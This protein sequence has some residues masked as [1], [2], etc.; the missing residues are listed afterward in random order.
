LVF[1]TIH[2]STAPST[3]GRILNLFPRDM[4]SALRSAMAFNSKAIIAQKLLPS[5]L[6]GVG[7]V[8]ACE[9][10]IF[11]PT[12]R[13]LLLEELDDK[14]GDAI[15]IGKDEGMQDFTMALLDLLDRKMIDRPTAFEMAPN[16]EALKMAMK[17]IIMKE[18]GML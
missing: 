4:H 2:A 7:R 18:S 6:P 13:K 10:M 9:I 16:P 11:S 15:R 8:P 5:I 3:I 1:G 12:V 14:V 17:G